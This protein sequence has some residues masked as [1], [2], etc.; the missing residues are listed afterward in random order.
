MIC[1]FKKLA[2]PF[3]DEDEDKD[4][5]L[6][7]IISRNIYPKILKLLILDKKLEEDDVCIA[8]TILIYTQ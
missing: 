5:F 7:N 6:F 4:I 3:Y 1:Y 2:N 8:C